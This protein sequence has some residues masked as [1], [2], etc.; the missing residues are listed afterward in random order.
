M[1]T[2]YI[3]NRLIGNHIQLLYR[4]VAIED[5][6]TNIGLNELSSTYCEYPL[7]TGYFSVLI[8]SLM[9]RHRQ[10]KK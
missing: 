3:L 2:W 8:L 6:K 5:T 1:S 4:Y 9:L 10:F 7:D